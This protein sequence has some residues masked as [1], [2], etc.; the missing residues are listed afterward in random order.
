[1]PEELK[2][3]DKVKCSPDKFDRGFGGTG[4][5]IEIGLGGK[6]FIKNDRDGV[7]SLVHK[8]LITKI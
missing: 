1:M 8:S 6:Y 7:I 5:I 4:T 2:I 3:G